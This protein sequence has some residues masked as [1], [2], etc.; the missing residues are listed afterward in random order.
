MAMFTK[1]VNK[2][3]RKKDEETYN[4]MEINLKWQNISS[5]AVIYRRT[6]QNTHIK[7]F[8]Y[9]GKQRKLK[10]KNACELKK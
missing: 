7:N 10:K 4:N 9:V 5:F 8:E 3:F 1:F 2:F 6:E